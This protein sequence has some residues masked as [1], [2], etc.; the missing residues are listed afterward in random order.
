MDRLGSVCL[1]K[2][3]LASH[4]GGAQWVEKRLGLRGKRDGGGV[5]R[6]VAKR[7]RESTAPVHCKFNKIFLSNLQ[8]GLTI[9]LNKV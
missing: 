2:R 4:G 3:P 9:M 1:L 6:S 5:A 7:N 8:Y